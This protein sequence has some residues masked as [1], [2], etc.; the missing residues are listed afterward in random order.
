M[1]TAGDN[2]TDR[3]DENV[4]DLVG[5]SSNSLD[6]KRRVAIPKAFREQI[7]GAG[8]EGAFVLCRQLGGDPCLALFAP[9]CFE[10]KLRGLEGMRKGS[11]GVGTKTVRAYLRKLRMSAARLLPD[12]QNRITLT[13]AQCA[14]AGISKEVAFVGCGDHLEL[15]SP[16]RLETTDETLD[17]GDLANEL[18]GDF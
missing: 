18:F 13:E 9:G 7:A 16:D 5:S 11:A 10:R 8:L 15:W 14:L 4:L 17:F 2:R 12:K 6:T 3:G 1:G